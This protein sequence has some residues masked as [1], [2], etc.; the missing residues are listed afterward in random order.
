MSHLWTKAKQ[1]TFTPTDNRFRISHYSALVPYTGA[2][3]KLL[4]FFNL[5]QMSDHSCQIP[6]NIPLS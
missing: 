2:I 6:N 5:L 4:C 3:T 1:E